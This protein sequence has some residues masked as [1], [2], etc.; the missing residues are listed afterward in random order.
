MGHRQ[1]EPIAQV[2]AMRV[3]EA[4]RVYRI[5]R[6]KLYA[7]LREGRLASVKIG[8]TRLIP[9]EALEALISPSEPP[10]RANASGSCSGGQRK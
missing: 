6:T 7:L 1:R 5:G 8:G 3:R 2:R 9:V 10:A 4:S